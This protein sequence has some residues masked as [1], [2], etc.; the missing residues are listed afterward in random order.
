MEFIG[1]KKELGILAEVFSS[2]KMEC[3]LVYGRRRIG[4]TELIKKA[5]QSLECPCIYYEA[6]QSSEMSNVSTLSELI[7]HNLGFPK[8]GFESFEEVLDFL[9]DQAKDRNMVFVLDEYPYLRS[10]IKGIDSIIQ[11]LVDKHLHTSRLKFVLCG[12]YVDTMKSLAERENPLYGRFTRT[13]D[14]KPMD[15]YESMMFYNSYSMEE[16]IALYSV[17]GGI[18]YYNQLIDS[19]KSVK[20]NIIRLIASP[21]AILNNE[22]FLYLKNEIAKINNANEVF[23]SL[24]MG[25]S[26]FTD[27]LSKSHISSSPLL[28]D[29]LDKLIK[30]E[31]VAKRAPINDKNNKKKSGYYICDN[32]I[33][34]YYKYIYRYSSQ[35]NVMNE[36]AFFE[37]FIEEDFYKSHVPYVFEN[38]CQQYLIRKNKENKITPPFFDI[39]KYYYDD[40]VNKKNGEFDVVTQDPNGYIFYECKYRNEKITDKLVKQEIGQVKQAGL[41]C[42]KYGFF[43]KS[44]FDVDTQ[45]NLILFDL[46]QLF[47]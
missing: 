43:S 37:Y 22:V 45:D 23:E 17:F 18:P 31:I 38:I 24:A 25:S 28:S 27:I 8:L 19:K 29:V 32:F 5:I 16:R 36:N 33:L 47:Q 15:Y 7:S 26:K 2:N 1:R 39:G 3:V 12:S 30:M 21:N 4:K 40:P 35:L 42:Y 41:D 20:D 9:F 6:K 11:T 34:F 14:L 44:G 13:I 46:E 10:C